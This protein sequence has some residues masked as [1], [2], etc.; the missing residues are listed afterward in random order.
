MGFSISM[1][2]T[3]NRCPGGILEET[4]ERLPRKE[5][6]LVGDS[7]LSTRQRQPEWQSLGRQRSGK[8]GLGA[9]GL[10]AHAVAVECQGD[11][12]VAA[13]AVLDRLGFFVAMEEGFPRVDIDRK[14]TRLNSSHLG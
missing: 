10:A 4:E 9:Q 5:A 2:A 14:S 13:D 1:R 7:R 11:V 6:A 3:E 12:L 8:P